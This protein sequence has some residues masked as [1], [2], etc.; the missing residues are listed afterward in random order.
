MIELYSIMAHI[1]KESNN[2][3]VYIIKVYIIIRELENTAPSGF[4]RILLIT[5]DSRTKFN[6]GR[7]AS[8]AL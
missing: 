5:N 6:V 3:R 4:S 7:K 8:P 2:I 1:T